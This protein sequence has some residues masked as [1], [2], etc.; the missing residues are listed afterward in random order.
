VDGWSLGLA[1]CKDTSV[2]AHIQALSGLGIDVYVAGLVMHSHETGD[3]ND[4]GQGI[5]AGFNVHVAFASFAGP[6]GSGYTVTAGVSS[7]WAPDGSLLAQ[8]G[9]APGDTTMATLYPSQHAALR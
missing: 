6:T 5:A 4:R 9:P 8:A 3:Q 1:I 7:I 2:A